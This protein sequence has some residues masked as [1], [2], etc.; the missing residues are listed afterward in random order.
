M[1]TLLTE[2][3]LRILVYPRD[4]PPIHVHVITKDRLL[5]VKIDISGTKPKVIRAAKNE[6]IKTTQKHTKR[7]LQLC[8]DNLAIIQRRANDVYNAQ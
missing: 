5:E 7:A 1:P 8:A 3:D 6:R 2:G 4:H